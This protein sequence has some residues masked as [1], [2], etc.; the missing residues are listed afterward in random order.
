MMN[1]INL[2]FGRP[3]QGLLALQAKISSQQALD[4]NQEK[5][6]Q[7][8]RRRL[9][10]LKPNADNAKRNVIVRAKS[11]AEVNAKALIEL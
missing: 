4:H 1:Q 2:L 8:S 9:V 5:S 11:R 7:N 10:E 3:I 6:L